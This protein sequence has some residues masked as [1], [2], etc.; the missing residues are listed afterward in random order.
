MKAAVTRAT[1]KGSTATTHV[2]CTGPAGSKCTV[3]LKLTVTELFRHH[4]LVGLTA[5]SKTTRKVLVVGSATVTLGAG[6][7]RIVHVGLNS[8]GK[9]LLAKRHVLKVR[10]QL[11]KPPA[12]L[13]S[14]G[15]PQIL[16][17]KAPHKHHH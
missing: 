14:S 1:V 16:T 11:S 12:G 10:L 7:S 2:T 17:F 13:S 5:R 4:R 6:Q 15:L 8:T 3:T 9:R